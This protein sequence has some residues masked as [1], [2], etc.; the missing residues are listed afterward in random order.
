MTIA[1]GIAGH[2][3]SRRDRRTERGSAAVFPVPPAPHAPP[4]G[5]RGIKVHN[6]IGKLKQH[7]TV[8][9]RY[10]KRDYIFNGTLATAAIVI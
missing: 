7:R 10:D 6:C 1:T 2:P 4:S 9:T 3:P 5:R 8:A